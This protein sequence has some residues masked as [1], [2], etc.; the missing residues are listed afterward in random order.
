[1][2]G[3]VRL[4]LHDPHVG[5]RRELA[6][7]AGVAMMLLHWLSDRMPVSDAASATRNV[8]VRGQ[9]GGGGGSSLAMAGAAIAVAPIAS[10][11]PALCRTQKP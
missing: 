3:A 4:R 6:G 11:S 2:F 1:V 10:P 9:G 5:R 7:R 8:V